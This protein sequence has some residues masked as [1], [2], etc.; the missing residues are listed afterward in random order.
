MPTAAIQFSTD[1]PLSISMKT[2][3]LSTILL[4]MN[5]SS[6]PFTPHK[7]GFWKLC[8]FTSRCQ[9]KNVWR[10]SR[11]WESDIELTVWEN[12]IG[13][14][15]ANKSHRLS[16]V[17]VHRHTIG[18][19]HRKLISL[20]LIHQVGVAIDPQL[21]VWNEIIFS[22]VDTR[23]DR[24]FCQVPMQSLGNQSRAIAQLWWVKVTLELNR[25]TNFQGDGVRGEASWR[26][27]VEKLGWIPSRLIIIKCLINGQISFR[28]LVREP[29]LDSE[30]EMVYNLIGRREYEALAKPPSIIE[31]KIQIRKFL[32]ID[33]IHFDWMWIVVLVWLR[34]FCFYFRL[35]WH[36]DECCLHSRLLSTLK[37]SL[38]L[39]QVSDFLRCHNGGRSN[40]TLGAWC[41][42]PKTAL[43]GNDR[44][45]GTNR[46]L[47][48]LHWFGFHLTH[49]GLEAIPQGI[50]KSGNQGVKSG[51]Y[52]R[53]S[54]LG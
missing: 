41:T 19:S 15:N 52:G 49:S 4:F 45:T 50:V 21:D 48:S 51:E 54:H 35:K 32:A 42:V 34:W 6:H 26:K 12:I 7:Y 22:T 5:L 36:L 46:H 43:A 10:T 2:L 13:Q 38:H 8:S 29:F 20:K 27:G 16:L 37:Y 17:F 31:I 33:F 18:Q 53:H 24:R 9:N 39:M 47:D 44:L 3:C 30:V 14:L 23:Q 25:R 40:G 1:T 28:R 11:S